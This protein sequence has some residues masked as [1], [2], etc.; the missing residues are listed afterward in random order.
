MFVYFGFFSSPTLGHIPFFNL[1]TFISIYFYQH[2]FPVQ[3]HTYVHTHSLFPS[4]GT[5]DVVR[6]L[7]GTLVSTEVAPSRR[8]FRRLS[9]CPPP[10]WTPPRR[11]TKNIISQARHVSPPT[12]SRPPY[13][14]I[15]I[16]S[17]SLSSPPLTNNNI[18]DVLLLPR[19]QSAG[20]KYSLNRKQ[21]RQTDRYTGQSSWR[22]CFTL[23][24]H[25]FYT[26]GTSTKTRDYINKGITWYAYLFNTSWAVKFLLNF[27][28][29]LHKSSNGY[30]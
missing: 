11:L 15:I 25:I 27:I 20:A 13:L 30:I 3:S 28:I 19:D 1:H 23:F 10:R 16:F 4:H 8:R 17:L 26:Y 14:H 7:L 9:V 29:C 12:V 5:L 21:W 18:I 22:A 6:V 2:I 24:P